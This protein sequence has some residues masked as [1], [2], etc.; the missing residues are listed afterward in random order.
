[1][2]S[3]IITVKAKHIRHGIQ[4]TATFCPVALAL[5]EAGIENVSVGNRE[6][7]TTYYDNGIIKEERAYHCPRSVTRFVKK[8]DRKGKKAVK[9][10]SFKLVPIS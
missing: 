7:N 4:E 1:M 2:S 8:F 5:K 3:Q 9:P 6:I 10:F